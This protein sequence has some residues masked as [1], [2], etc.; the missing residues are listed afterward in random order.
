VS[1]ALA[2]GLAGSRFGEN[3]QNE[4]EQGAQVAANQSAPFRCIFAACGKRV[5]TCP[6]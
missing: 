6:A 3:K 4:E 1:G 2:V 5:A